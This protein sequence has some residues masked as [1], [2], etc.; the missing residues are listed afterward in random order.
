MKRN[1]FIMAIDIGTTSVKCLVVDE[2][3]A[4]ISSGSKGYPIINRKPSW[5]EQNPT[6]WWN[7]VIHSIKQA[8]NGVHAEDIAV[9]SFSGHMSA[10]VLVDEMGS[11]IYPSILIA[12][13][14]ST[15][16]TNYLRESY[17][18]R[19]IEH[20]GNEPIDA[21][22][23]SKLMWIKEEEPDVFKRVTKFF[24][25]KDYIR[26][27]LTDRIGT[28]PTDAGNSLLYDSSKNEWIGGL[29]TELEL[30]KEIFPEI[31][32][33]TDIFGE[34]TEK[35]AILT[36]LRAGTPVVTGGADMACSQIGTGAVL[37]GTVAIT[38]STSG[39]V[40]AAIPAPQQQG[41]GKVTFHPGAKPNSMY[42]M[43]TIF[44]GGLGVE[45]GY[46]FLYN[47]TKM[48]NA[49]YEELGVLTEKMKQFQ[50]GSNGLM[51][52]PFLVGSSTPYF[53]PR[54]KAAWIGLTLHQ[55]KALLMHSILEGITLNLLE[56]INVLRDMGI[57]VNKVNLGAGGSKNPVWCQMITD[58]L[59]VD[60]S[61]LANKDGSAIGAAIIGG[62][63]VGLFSSI[64]EA[65]KKIVSTKDTIPYNPN[66]HK[67]Y[68]TIFPNYQ[69]LYHALNKYYHNT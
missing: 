56:N 68:Q 46:K 53:D 16:Q 14:R 57:S 41:I 38:L 55:E 1:R 2:K 42:T 40:V 39:Q 36:G 22:T 43:G 47:K 32:A 15:N 29:I 69:N 44:T 21:F 20:T 4:Q 31:V 35:A 24:F 62:V 33:T 17:M 65:T 12:D 30:P 9:I 3:G 18:D 7:A 8:L 58:A 50:P 10:L 64:D 60:V 63:G 49:D 45:W 28:D 13:T 54:D 6:D 27:Q 19:F 25:P 66:K 52:L 26:Y 5:V 61:L 59:G 11:P 23:V 48:T 34:V 67:Q 37:D 51:F